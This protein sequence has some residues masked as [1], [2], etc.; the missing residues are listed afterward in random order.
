MTTVT[1][2]TARA[3]VAT[4]AFATHLHTAVMRLIEATPIDRLERRLSE[5]ERWVNRLERD[6]HR[7]T[8]DLASAPGRPHHAAGGRRRA[9]RPHTR[10]HHLPVEREMARPGG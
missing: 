4:K 7:L 5:L 8:L 10:I 6:T 9:G 3:D 2:R 1:E